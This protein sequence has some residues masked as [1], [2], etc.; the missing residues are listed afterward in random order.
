MRIRL[1]RAVSPAEL[2]DIGSCNGFR[3]IT[4]SLEG[5]WF[6]ESDRHARK[7]GVL[8]HGAVTTSRI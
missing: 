5:K 2:A 7:W 4:N 3:P 8:L 1:F 6:A